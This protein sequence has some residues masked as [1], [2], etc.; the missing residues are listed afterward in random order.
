M[1]RMAPSNTPMHQSGALVLKEALIC[2]VPT[3]KIRFVG[4]APHEESPAGDWQSR[5]TATP[6][7][8]IAPRELAR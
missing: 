8:G 4:G 5:Y 3:T 2:A 1:L 7:T 6:V